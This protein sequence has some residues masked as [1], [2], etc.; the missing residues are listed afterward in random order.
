MKRGLSCG[1]LFSIL[2]ITGCGG[3]ARLDAT[4]MD[5][6]TTSRKAMEAPMT[7]NQKRQ[8]A[9]DLADALGPEA[10]QAAMKNTFSK[11]KT[12]T[13]PNEPYKLLQGMNAEEIHAKAEQNRQNKKKR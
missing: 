7:D 9:S 5:S 12:T 6:F 11:E 8:L 13:S 2:A 3:G 4:S 10:A 1:F